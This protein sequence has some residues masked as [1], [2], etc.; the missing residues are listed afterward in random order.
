LSK[1]AGKSGN[2]TI[3]ARLRQRFDTAGP[4]SA[5]ELAELTA[6]DCAALF[7]Q[8]LRPPVDELMALYARALND[9]GAF[10]RRRFDGSFD[11]LVEEA[12]GSAVR[13]VDLLLEM[14][15][16]R[17]VAVYDGEPVP[18]LKRAQL[19]ASD[20]GG[21]SDLDQLTLFA[22]NLIPHV[23]RVEGVLRLDDA[24]ATAI[25]DEELL[26]PGGRAE[27][28]LRAGAVHVGEL[29]A[30]RS[31]MAVTPREVDNHL[32]CLGQEQRFKASPRP[33]IRTWFY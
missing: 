5:D 1:L 13:L 28:E 18:F 10:L 16:Y 6:S 9:L 2:A 29:M 22:D 24:L 31:A 25:D 17:D 30:A 14:P 3:T 26:E 33:R 8:P 27:V 7:G 21:F 4:F 20:I 15:M 23:L 19:T 11:G 32:W 12:D